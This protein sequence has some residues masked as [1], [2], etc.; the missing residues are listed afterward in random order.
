MSGKTKWFEPETTHAQVSNRTV[1]IELYGGFGSPE[2]EQGHVR[3]SLSF[4][5]VPSIER[6][7]RE[8][9][10]SPVADPKAVRGDLWP[11]DESVDDFLEL[12][13]GGVGKGENQIIS[14]RK[15]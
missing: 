7:A 15:W 10:V 3:R 4:D 9:G 8:Q 12:V 5:E 6:R 14:G 13:G 1:L 11:E 2:T